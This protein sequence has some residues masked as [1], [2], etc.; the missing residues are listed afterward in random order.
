VV[1]ATGQG[2]QGVKMEGG[3]TYAE[4]TLPRSAPKDSQAYTIT[5]SRAV[6][7]QDNFRGE[8][9]WRSPAPKSGPAN[10]VVN[11]NLPGAAG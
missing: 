6:T 3:N 7:P 1:N 5:L 4:W 2:Y 11:I 10:D 8:V 9:R